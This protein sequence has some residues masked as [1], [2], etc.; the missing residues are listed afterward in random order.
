M[1]GLFGGGGTG[2]LG[3]SGMM[4]PDV[5]VATGMPEMFQ[6]G[7]AGGSLPG[8]TNFGQG[9][10]GIG[11]SGSRNNQDP[12]L[13]PIMPGPLS[14]GGARR[15]SGD[16]PGFVSQPLRLLQKDPLLG[17]VL[18]GMN[19]DPILQLLLGQLMGGKGGF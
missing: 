12:G 2:V 11:T 3:S 6:V 13:M 7:G 10:L 14:P 4:A 1:N 16:V 17:G 15:S 19:A 5:P 18:Q 8:L 9:I